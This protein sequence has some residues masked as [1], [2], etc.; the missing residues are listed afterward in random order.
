MKITIKVTPEAMFLLHKIILAECQKV[1]YQRQMK[2]KLSIMQELF[3]SLSN[4][5]IAY[6]SN[7][8]GKERV[9]TLKYYQADCLFDI[10][11]S[12]LNGRLYGS[13]ELNTMELIK[14]ELH[15]KLM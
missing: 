7:P 9:L 4:R 11:C 1:A 15:Q 10:L 13:Y 12:R 5:C 14:N 6:T 3:Q 8:N 2:V